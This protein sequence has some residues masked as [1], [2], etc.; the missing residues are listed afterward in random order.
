MNEVNQLESLF[1]F[2]SPKTDINA[3]ADVIWQVFNG[4][5]VNIP[6]IKTIDKV[7]RRM[8]GLFKK[9]DSKGKTFHAGDLLSGLFDRVCRSFL[10]LESRSA[11]GFFKN[12][13]VDTLLFLEEFQL[14]DSGEKQSFFKSLQAN[15]ELFPDEIAKYKILPKLIYVSP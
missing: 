14:K 3:L 4:F 5:H 15:L 10:S 11:G 1:L 9:L 8:H 13:F 6:A 7:P 2:R 12:K